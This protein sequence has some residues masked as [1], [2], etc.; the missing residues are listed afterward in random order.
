MKLMYHYGIMCDWKAEMNLRTPKTRSGIT[1][2][3]PTDFHGSSKV[4]AQHYGNHAC[5]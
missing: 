4:A 2:I 5:S 3:G 1:G